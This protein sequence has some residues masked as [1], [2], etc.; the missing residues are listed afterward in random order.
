MSSLERLG[1]S[2]FFQDQVIAEFAPFR[3]ARVIEEQRGLCRVAG[4][5]DGWAEVSGRF[6]HEAT[7]AADFP[8]VGDW[9]GVAA[10]PGTERAVIHRRLNRRSTVSRKA[11]GRAVDEQVLAA[12]VDTIFLVTALTGDLNPRRIERYLTMVWEAGA[13]PVVVLNKADLCEEPF[14]AAEATRARLPFVDVLSL[15]ALN[16]DGLDQLSPYLTR[17]TTIALLGSSGVGK[18]TLVNRLLG[19]DLQKV[20]A[21]SNVDGRGRHTTTSRQLVELA[22]GALLIDT[23][24]MRELQPWVDESAIDGAFEDIAQLARACRFSDCAHADEPDCAVLEAVT[25]G[26]LDASRLE[27]YRRLLREAAFEERKR[28]KSAAA[29]EKRRWKRINQAMKV[30]Y[31]HKDR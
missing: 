22:S 26:T 19:H 23:P 3:M 14:A 11:A 18:S 28:D 29:E 15:S 10:E 8:A 21:V 27:H 25:S 4:D 24:G 6:R 20:A 17:A 13:V 5:F 31:R 12:N 1:W 30:L 9:V 7:S 2:R 16:A